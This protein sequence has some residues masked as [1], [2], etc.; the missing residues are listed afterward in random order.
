MKNPDHKPNSAEKAI[1]DYLDIRAK[2]TPSLP[3]HTPSQTRVSKSATTTSSPK[4][5]NVALQSA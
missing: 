2:T 4:L 5:A 3:F 1:K